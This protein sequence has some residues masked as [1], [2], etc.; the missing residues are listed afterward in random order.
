MK[1]P[2]AVV[3]LAAGAG[4]RMK[5]AIPKVLHPLAGW[6]MVRHVLENV[7]RLRPARVVGVVAPGAKDVAAAF[8]PHPTAVQRRPSKAISAPCWWSMPTRPC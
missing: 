3:V 1:P 4:T 7:S 5:S 2:V 8:A 6:P